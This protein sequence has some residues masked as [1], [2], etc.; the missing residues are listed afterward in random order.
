MYRATDCQETDWA[1]LEVEALKRH[2]CLNDAF[3]ADE[4]WKTV[5]RI[6]LQVLI[7]NTR[8]LS[9]WSSDKYTHYQQQFSFF[10]PLNTPT[11]TSLANPV[12][13]FF[14][15][16]YNPIRGT[17]KTQIQ[18]TARL[19]SIATTSACTKILSC[20]CLNAGSWIQTS[21]SKI[22]LTI[23]RFAYLS[24]QYCIVASF[25]AVLLGFSGSSS[26][27]PNSVSGEEG[28]VGVLMEFEDAWN[29][30]HGRTCLWWRPCSTTHIPFQAAMLVDKPSTQSIMLSQRHP[31]CIPLIANTNASKIPSRISAAPRPRAKMTRG[32]LP[33]QMASRMK[34]GWCC[35]RREASTFWD[36]K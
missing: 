23:F 4:Q 2:V 32:R 22:F 6:L 19:T 5:F 35:W 9:A 21:L 15:I 31:R 28:A 24:V 25:L 3:I 8:L 34:L 10:Y 26:N 33:L 12:S 11:Y 17:A 1:T 30:S 16:Q 13:F 14:S 27:V 29:I 18:V 36:R 20:T 7:E